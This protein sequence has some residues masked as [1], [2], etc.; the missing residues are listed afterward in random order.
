MKEKTV[1]PYEN[2][3]CKKCKTKDKPLFFM[4]KPTDAEDY[5]CKECKDETIEQ[6]ATQ[7][8]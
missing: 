8:N 2:T 1:P 6:R 4:P 5:F 7:S 3:E